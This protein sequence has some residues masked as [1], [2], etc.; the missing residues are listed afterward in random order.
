MVCIVPTWIALFL[1]ASQ[2]PKLSGHSYLILFYFEKSKNFPLKP[3]SFR[4]STKNKSN[5][6]SSLLFGFRLQSLSGQ[7]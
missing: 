7:D 4:L 6:E 1:E 3:M 5:K 2:N